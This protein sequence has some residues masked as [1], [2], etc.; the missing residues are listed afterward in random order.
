[1]EIWE[2]S[3]LYQDNGKATTQ[4]MLKAYFSGMT[5]DQKTAIVTWMNKAENKVA[6][7]T[8]LVNRARANSQA[9]LGVYKAGS[10]ASVG[11][12]KNV[13]QAAGPY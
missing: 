2:G 13:D 5:E 3:K 8:A 6:A 1:M 9:N 11:A 4:A 12:S 10:C 7:Q